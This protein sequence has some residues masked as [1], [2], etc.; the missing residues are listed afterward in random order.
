MRPNEGISVSGGTINA[1]ALAVGR[2]AR[3]TNVVEAASRT[4][5]ARGHAELAERLEELIHAL[6]AHASE[7]SNAAELL[8]ATQVV[9]EELVKERPNKT[10]VT[11]VLAG[12]AA[13]VK[14]VAGLA[15]A[16]EALAHAVA[17]FL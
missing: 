12:I 3:A 13:G 9:A 7:L 6:D 17:A 5:E 14:S 10:T 15:G 4:L 1:G 11:G 2:G 8:Q 16:A